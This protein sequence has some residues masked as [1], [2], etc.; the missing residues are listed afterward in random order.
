MRLIS[1]ILL[2]CVCAAV[3]SARAMDRWAALS[4]IES[5]NDDLAV[6]SL[7][8]ISRYQIRPHLWPGGNPHNAGDALQ[9]ARKIMQPRIAR[10]ERS[11]HH[12]PTDFEFYELWNAPQEIG[13]PCRAV[14]ERARRFANLVERNQVNYANR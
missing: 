13:H 2:V 7:G 4:M 11:H 6:G 3:S 8:E 9:A 14:A 1:F 12:A 5:G 10:F